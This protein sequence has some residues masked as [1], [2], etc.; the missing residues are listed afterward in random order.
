MAPPAAPSPA[1]QTQGAFGRVRIRPDV[2]TFAGVSSAS[3][4][5]RISQRG[6]SYAHFSYTSGG[7]N[8]QPNATGVFSRFNARGEAVW[9][10]SPTAQVS[11]GCPLKFIGAGYRKAK[12]V[13]IVR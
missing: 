1:L 13:V 10:I 12:L 4:Q 3:K 6:Y 8:C 2:L 5:I 7:A 11:H 9:L